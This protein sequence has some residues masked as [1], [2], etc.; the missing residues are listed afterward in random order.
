MKRILVLIVAVFSLPAAAHEIYT[1]SGIY[2]TPLNKKDGEMNTANVEC[3]NEI[4]LLPTVDNHKFYCTSAVTNEG[5]CKVGVKFV[6][7][8]SGQV[9]PVLDEE[10]EDRDSKLDSVQ[11]RLNGNNQTVSCAI[12][13]L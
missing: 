8:L 3:G 9:Q 6:S 1:L 11:S 4:E 10:D 5:S 12:I 13:K 7:G 2:T